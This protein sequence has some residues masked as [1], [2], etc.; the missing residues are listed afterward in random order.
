MFKIGDLISR[1][2]EPTLHDS[3]HEEE[4]SGPPS[5]SYEVNMTKHQAGASK[6]TGARN[7]STSRGRSDPS[8][9]DEVLKICKETK[10]D[11]TLLRNS[12]DNVIQDMATMKTQVTS[13]ENRVKIVEDNSVLLTNRVV[14]L[15]SKERES[16]SEME[17]RIEKKILAK[18][19][20]QQVSTK[21]LLRPPTSPAPAKTNPALGGKM[22][23]KIHEAFQDLLRAADARKNTFLFG[24]IEQYTPTGA[25][26]RPLLKYDRIVRRFLHGLRYEMKPL[27]RAQLTDM[28]LGKVVIH[29]EDVHEAK[30]R[31]RDRWRETRNYGWWVG[32]ENPPD[33]RQMQA[34]AFRF[35]MYSKKV[36]EELRRFYLEAED[37]FI[38]FARVPFLPVYLVPT[39]ETKWKDLSRV[40][41]KMVK[42]VRGRDW[43]DRFQGVKE[44][45]PGLVAEWN[46]I[47]KRTDYEDED[48]DNEASD[49]EDV[50]EELLVSSKLRQVGRFQGRGPPFGDLVRQ[51]NVSTF[52][53]APEP[54]PTTAP[55][56]VSSPAA[57]AHVKSP[58][59]GGPLGETNATSTSSDTGEEESYG[60]AH[61]GNGDRLMEEDDNGDVHM[62]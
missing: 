40:L 31:V 2:T 47:L 18:L 22:G 17:A 54:S 53:V 46:D 13:V 41:L 62:H 1:W 11:T 58:V 15:E 42:S 20:A 27:G 39:K 56:M 7:R 55:V 49:D 16:E 32:Q 24:V 5:L 34:N 25:Q 28:P 60:S 51:H 6:P 35:I 61:D 12:I 30:L 10:E 52:Q 33:L 45:E 4:I 23:K 3:P 26:L 14:E 36:C 9:L 43:V 29:P 8:V 38:R 50:S 19:Q 37:G 44:L 21:P 57:A 48:E 59:P